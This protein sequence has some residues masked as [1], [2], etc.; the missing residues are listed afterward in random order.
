MDGALGPEGSMVLAE[1]QA[2]G[3][4]GRGRKGMGLYLSQ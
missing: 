1:E 2:D 4:M 3:V